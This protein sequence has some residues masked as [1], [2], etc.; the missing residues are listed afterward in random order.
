MREK[1]T[2]ESVVVAYFDPKL[3]EGD[4]EACQC[5]PYCACEGYE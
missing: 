5:A 3:V 1:A 2:P 4:C